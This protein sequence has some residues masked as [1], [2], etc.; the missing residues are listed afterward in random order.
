MLPLHLRSVG[1]VRDGKVLLDDVSLMVNGG[2]ITVLLGANGAGKSQLL[3]L[4]AG[5]M[6]PSSG[7]V[8]WDGQ[9]VDRA[10]PRR[11]AFV[12]QSAVLLRRSVEGNISHMMRAAGYRGAEC[13][14]RVAEALDLARL[15]QKRRQSARTLSAGECQRLA[16]ARALATSPACL[17]MDEPTANLDPASTLAIED[18]VRAAKGNGMGILL[19]TH[20]G[21][22]ARRLADDVYFLR[23]GRIEGHGPAGDMLGTD[24]PEALRAYLDGRLDE[25]GPQADIQ[26]K[27]E[28]I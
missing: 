27:V 23:A 5:L 26:Q 4:A 6:R 13:K 1:L 24:G 7:E 10:D 12:F 19:V 15:V 14:A 8:L 3:R 18:M 16:V 17:F 9:R 20:D 22:Q 25:G 28:G 2:H 11:L 21:G